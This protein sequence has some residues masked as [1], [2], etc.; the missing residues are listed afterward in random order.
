MP[1]NITGKRTKDWTKRI[2]LLFF[3]SKRLCSLPTLGRCQF[4][5]V[6][7]ASNRPETKKSLYDKLYSYIPRMYP[8]SSILGFKS[9]YLNTIFTICQMKDP[10]SN[11]V[12]LT[13]PH[14][15]KYVVFT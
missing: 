4:I 8:Y 10:I 7:L 6:F 1:P 5:T 11:F 12:G 14:C 15:H 9:Q 13:C 2:K 3:I